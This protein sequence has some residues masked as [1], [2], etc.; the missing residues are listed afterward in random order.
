MALFCSMAATKRF[1]V[2]I[3]LGA[4]VRTD[5]PN[6][7]F[8]ASEAAKGI[9]QV[10]LHSGVPVT[11]GV[12]TADTVDQA[13]ERAGVRAGNRGWDAALNAIEMATL[14]AQLD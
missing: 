8:V 7:D 14:M 5:S 3:C 4:I 12:I 2:L 6:F 9:A 11:F 13:V 1:D 10:G